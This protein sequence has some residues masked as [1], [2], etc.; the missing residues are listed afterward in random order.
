MPAHPKSHLVSQCLLL[1]AWALR[2]LSSGDA[3]GFPEVEPAAFHLF[4]AAEAIAWPLSQRLGAAAAGLPEYARDE[5]TRAGREELQRI[6][7]ARAELAWLDRMAER[8]GVAPVI[9][10][11]AVA[12]TDGS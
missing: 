1:R 11:G 2:F 8:A 9:L 5:L 3:S 10:K 4:V 6:M 7:A 12:V